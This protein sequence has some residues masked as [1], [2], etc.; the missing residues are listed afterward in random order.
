[1]VENERIEKCAEATHR[2][3][4]P[5]EGYAIGASSFRKEVGASERA[6]SPEPEG[7][8]LPPQYYGR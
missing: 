5:G 6:Q 3:D 8:H 1:M 2:T 4:V 7:Q